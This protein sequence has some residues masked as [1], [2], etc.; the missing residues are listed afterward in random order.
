MDSGSASSCWPRITWS[1]AKPRAVVIARNFGLDRELAIALQVLAA[2]HLAEGDDGARVEPLLR[3]S[4]AALQRDP[5]LFWSARALHLLAIARIRRGDHEG[6][7]RLVGVAEVV[8]ETIGAGM[9][10]SDRAYLEPALHAARAAMG[11]AAF[12]AAWKAG[13]GVSLAAAFDD[14]LSQVP[15]GAA[16]DAVSSSAESGRVTAVV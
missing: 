5:S 3:E 13:R 2:V 15:P 11:D 4:L 14:I 7:A 12:D 6:G 1:S 16:P 8:R 9:L 10:G